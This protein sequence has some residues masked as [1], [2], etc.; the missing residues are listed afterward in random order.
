MGQLNLHISIDKN[1]GFCFGVVNAIRKAEQHLTGENA[2]HC[3]GEIV[4][5]DE[6]I[7]RLKTEGLNTINNEELKQ[8]KN[9]TVL[10]RAHG[11]PPSSYEMA[12]QNNIA[13]IDATCTI[14]I[15]LQ[16][17]LKQSYENGEAIYIFGKKNHPEIIGLNGQINNAATIFEHLEELQLS[18]LPKKL[19]LYSQTT[20]SLDEFKYIAKT[21][22][23]YGIDVKVEDSVCRQVANRETELKK[24]AL[25]YD[26]IVFVAGKKSSNGKVLF[27]YCEEVNE[28]SY[29]VSTPE[30]IDPSWFLPNETIGISGATSTPLWLMENVK[31]HLEKL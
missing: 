25:N 21:L 23:E 10:F 11:E 15:K 17:R 2:L 18:L 12:K 30:E 29:F 24:F 9:T 31:K 27:H 4:H 22:T 8:L 3:L 13:I 26:K 14:I 28:H 20:K 7:M 1:S 16:K 6:E 5:N 19:T